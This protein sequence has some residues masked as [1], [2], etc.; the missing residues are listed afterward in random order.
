[1]TSDI[2]LPT[3]TA[4]SVYGE[5]ECYVDDLVTRQI[6]A[7]GNHTRPEFAFAFSALDADMA[8]FD[9]GA[10]IGTFALGAAHKIGPAGRLLCIEGAQQSFEMLKRNLASHAK[11]S[12]SSVNAFL[13]AD[14]TFVHEIAA[15]NV[16]A[17]HLR[18]SDTGTAVAGTSLDALVADHFAPDFLKIDIE[19]LELAML[20]ASRW[21]RDNSPILYMEV[22]FEQLERAGGSAAALNRLL[23]R[24]G[25]YF[26]VNTGPR[27]GRHDFFR[28]REIAD[29][30][31]WRPFFDV[32]CV[33]RAS[34]LLR[35]LRQVS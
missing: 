17:S 13:G 33:H 30:L 23:K 32:L 2:P 7:F 3:R 4:L 1:M 12:F 10:H 31:A 16:G 22:A 21:F 11:C 19:G 15:D 6:E 27:N 20:E 24:Q 8:V 9:C 28:V 29:L 35:A 14:G 25:Y 5:V 34:P 26:F 18:P